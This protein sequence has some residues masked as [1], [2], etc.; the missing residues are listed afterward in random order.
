MLATR[1]ILLVLILILLNWKCYKTLKNPSSIDF[2]LKN[3]P[4]SFQKS[5]VMKT[6]LS[7][8]WSMI[9]TTTKITFQIY[10]GQVWNYGDYKH[11]YNENYRQELLTETSNSY[12][13][14]DNEG[15]TKVFELGRVVLDR[16]DPWK[17]NSI[18][19]TLSK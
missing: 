8:F 16:H 17:Q 3:K 19:K 10:K 7:D 1:M 15:F 18:N 9:L 5:C 6:D 4:H 13:R 11:F 14:F 12:L 2:I